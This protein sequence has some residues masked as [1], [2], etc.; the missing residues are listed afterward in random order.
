MK[1][2]TLLI[3]KL[4]VL[5]AVLA[6]ISSIFILGDFRGFS[7]DFDNRSYPSVSS[8]DDL[9]KE[10]NIIDMEF[11]R[12]EVRDI[13]INMIYESIDIVYH[14]SDKIKVV[15]DGSE[16]DKIV[17]G[18]SNNQLNVYHKKNIAFNFFNSNR[19]QLTIYLPENFENSMSVESVSGDINIETKAIKADINTTSGEIVIKESIIS[20]D[21]NTVSGNITVNAPTSDAEFE[22][23][24]GD[25]D[26]V[27]DVKC[28]VSG[29]SVSGSFWFRVLG[30][31]Y[32]VDFDSVSGDLDY[33]ADIKI[34]RDSRNSI[35]VKTVSGD[36]K[37]SK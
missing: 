11:N 33:T 20:L 37:I 35:E 12:N 29:N 23:V 30:D 15:Y 19:G 22:T 24:S 17:V 14:T 36:L 8:P 7:F 5:I 4:V 1:N 26:A 16:A 34:V 18:T 28:D 2:R 25:V 3:V 13:H 9:N 32:E 31:E 10:E 27:I 6:V 21:V